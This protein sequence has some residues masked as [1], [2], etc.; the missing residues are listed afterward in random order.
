MDEPIVVYVSAASE[1]ESVTI[2]RALVE[3]RLAACVS[4]IPKIRSIY[5][6]EKTICDEPEYYLIIKTRR[7]LFPAL[8]RRVKTL[9][10]Y[11]V[12]EIVAFPILQAS[13][14]YLK[15]IFEETV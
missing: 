11:A 2:A 7:Q 1:Q 14:D 12:P 4:I 13:D 10:S 5:R 15:W 8:E 6:W 9:H 3:E